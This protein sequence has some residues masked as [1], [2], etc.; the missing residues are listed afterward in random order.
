MPRSPL[1]VDIARDV[2][3]LQTIVEQLLAVTR[4]NALQASPTDKVNM[5]DLLQEVVG[6]YAPLILA[7]NRQ[8]ELETP[9]TPVIVKG[10]KCALQSV[11]SNYIDNALRV[12]PEGGCINIC[13]SLTGVLTVADHGEGVRPEDRE[14]IFEPFWPKE[15]RHAGALSLRSQKKF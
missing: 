7:S 10:V 12:E 5:T 9:E 14:K 2:K 6:D 15:P 13:V 4:L 8:I 3:R 11:V 1:K